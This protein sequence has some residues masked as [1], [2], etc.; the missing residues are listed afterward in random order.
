MAVSTVNTSREKTKRVV[1][2]AQ[3]LRGG[4]LAILMLVVGC[5][6]Q[7]GEA[8]WQDYLTRLA[9]L[10][11]EPIPAA[12]TATRA[13]YP[14]QRELTQPVTQQRTGLLRYL[15][16][17]DC[18]L[19][20]LV[21]ERNSSLGRVQAGSLRLQHELQ[22]IAGAEHCLSGEVLEDNPDMAQWLSEIVAEKRRDLP[23]RGWNISFAGPEVARFFR[24][25]PVPATP[26]LAPHWQT[27]QSAMATLT[28]QIVLLDMSQ[29][30][31]S[32]PAELNPMVERALEALD[33]NSDGGV[34]LDAMA[35]A[36]RDLQRAATMLEQVNTERLCPH[37]RASERA[38]NLHSMFYSV[39]ADRVQ[40]WLADL[41]RSAIPLA[42]STQALRQAQQGIVSPAMDDWLAR[43][44]G[45]NGLLANY[46]QAL[47]HHSRAWQRVLGACGLMPAGRR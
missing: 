15:A 22:F 5:G 36:Q 28:Q 35:L 14:R 13:Q 16:L 41:S 4:L 33:K 10:T 47:N 19:I 40:P 23:A 34:L 39:Y 31:K 44:F 27:N 26:P 24:Q 20:H 18:D 30:D 38:R 8:L 25:R 2:S 12:D 43:Q 1:L 42:D 37:G 9:R 46:Q 7:T 11:G 29:P 21:S 17:T 6:P 45:D 3:V 32:S